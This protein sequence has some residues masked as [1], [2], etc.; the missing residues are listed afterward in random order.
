MLLEATPVT[1]WGGYIVCCGTGTRCPLSGL[2]AACS[3]D[4]CSNGWCSH[5]LACPCT[6]TPGRPWL[7][8]GLL[9]LLL[10]LLLQLLLQLLCVLLLLLRLLVG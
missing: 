1:G 2:P 3:G 6:A 10:L 5:P 7:L 8:Q 9:L 4:S